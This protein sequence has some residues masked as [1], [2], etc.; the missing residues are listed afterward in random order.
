M[1]HS[2]PVS[3]ISAKLQQAGL[4]IKLSYLNIHSKHD[5]FFGIFSCM[6]ESNRDCDLGYKILIF[7]DLRFRQA[8][9]QICGFQKVMIRYRHLQPWV[10]GDDA[11]TSGKL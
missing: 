2:G 1:P 4:W 3:G 11:F 7:K 9:E 5:L 10:I 8:I 6:I